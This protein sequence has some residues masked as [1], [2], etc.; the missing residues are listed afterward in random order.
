M[1]DWVDEL[2][3]SEDK[4]SNLMGLNLCMAGIL[5]F[6][7]FFRLATPAYEIDRFLLPSIRI[8]RRPDGRSIQTGRKAA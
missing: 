1:N 6:G 5:E 2:E 3:H 8:L 7:D 4:K